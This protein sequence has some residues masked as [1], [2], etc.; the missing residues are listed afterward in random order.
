MFSTPRSMFRPPLFNGWNSG[1]EGLNLPVRVQT[2]DVA[3]S[4]YQV[5]VR[6]V[7]LEVLK[8]D[9]EVLRWEGGASEPPLRRF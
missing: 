1:L 8:L 4:I 7:G 6:H 3:V 9:G 5:R 2:L